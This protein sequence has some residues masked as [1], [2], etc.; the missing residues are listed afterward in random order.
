MQGEDLNVDIKSMLLKHSPNGH[1]ND[2][3][4]RLMQMSMVAGIIGKNKYRKQNLM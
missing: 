3:G 4:S 1:V 2:E